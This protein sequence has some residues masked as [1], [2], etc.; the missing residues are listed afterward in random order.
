[1]GEGVRFVGEHLH[2]LHVRH[3]VAEVV[4]HE[5]P[6]ATRR[7]GHVREQTL[8]LPQ[9]RLEAVALDEVEQLLFAFEVVV[10]PGKADP[11]LLAD[12]PNA[13]LMI[14][15][16]SEDRRSGAEDQLELL[17]VG[18]SL[19]GHRDRRSFE[20]PSVKLEGPVCRVK[21]RRTCGTIIPGLAS[22]LPGRHR[23][24]AEPM[25]SI[26]RTPPIVAVLGGLA[27]AGCRDAPIEPAALVLA[28][29]TEAALRVAASLPALPQLVER[30]RSAGS[31][32]PGE[33]E[34]VAE[35][36]A[37]WVQADSTAN[38][39]AVAALRRRSYALAAPVL[40][41]SL[42]SAGL[43]EVEE[44]LRQ[45]IELA[46]TALDGVSVPGVADALNT[47]RALLARA[48]RADDPVRAAELL[49]EAGDR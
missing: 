42:G 17:V 14:A 23:R 48:A 5:D 9:N 30:A 24:S 38:P 18:G 16:V 35:A 12:V 6:Q 28:A 46:S 19:F 11:R 39:R 15:L 34:A 2:L 4:L 49:L 45:W 43:T 20:R 10:E 1:P 47:A 13:R 25:T 22:R 31:L 41:R 3:E 21:Y 32:Q 27:V 8:R 26:P 40:A 37:L 33:A 36:Y 44:G 29:A 7:V